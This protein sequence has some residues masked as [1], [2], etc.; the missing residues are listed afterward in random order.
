MFYLSDYL[1]SYFLEILKHSC[2]DTHFNNLNVSYNSSFSGIQFL[3]MDSAIRA[4]SRF[5][6]ELEFPDEIFSTK[7]KRI[8]SVFLQVGLYVDIVG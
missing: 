2:F 8:T 7:Y 3:S 6:P 1:P 5:V 4:V